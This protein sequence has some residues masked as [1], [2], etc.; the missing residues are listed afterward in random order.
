MMYSLEVSKFC[1]LSNKVT[2]DSYKLSM[3]RSEVVWKTTSM[4][5]KYGGHI[6]QFITSTQ[7]HSVFHYCSF[8]VTSMQKCGSN[9]ID[10]D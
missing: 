8:L 10:D 5:N 4:L 3:Y 9:V 6:N 7:L 2:V 1:S